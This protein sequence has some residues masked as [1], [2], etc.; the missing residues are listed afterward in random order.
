M[1][2]RG[3]FEITVKFSGIP[4]SKV[5]SR[6]TTRVEV[7]C[8][9][10]VVLASVKTKT[11]QRFLEKTMEYDYWEGVMHGK[12]VQIKGHQLFLAQ[13]GIQCHERQQVMHAPSTSIV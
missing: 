7:F 13:A 9:G 6:Q 12:L 1:T 8:E 10:F 4:M 11:F 3:Q 2:A 5:D